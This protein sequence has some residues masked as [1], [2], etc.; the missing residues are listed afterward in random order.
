[1]LALV[2]SYALLIEMTLVLVYTEN[3]DKWYM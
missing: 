2:C 3:L 1:M